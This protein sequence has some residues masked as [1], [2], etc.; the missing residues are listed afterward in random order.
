MVREVIQAQAE[1]ISA[2]IRLHD[3]AELFQELRL[4]IRRQA[5]HF[6][7]VAKFPEAHVL[8]ERRVVH[9]Q[10]M[11]KRDRAVHTATR[12]PSPVAHMVL[13]KSPSPSAESAAAFSKGETKNVLARCA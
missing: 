6:V 5:H 4:S 11:R 12:E 3:L 7:F 8:R 10:R 1:T 13:A 9:A 2:V